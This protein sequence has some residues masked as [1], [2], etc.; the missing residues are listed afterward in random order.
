MKL[1]TSSICPKCQ[2]ENEVK[3]P[4]YGDESKL[5]IFCTKCY[6][7]YIVEFEENNQ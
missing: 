3:Q 2:A 1:S 7:I 6:E 5:A 4:I